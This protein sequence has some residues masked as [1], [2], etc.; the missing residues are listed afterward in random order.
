MQIFAFHV[1]ETQIGGW[2]RS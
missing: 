2:S 1:I